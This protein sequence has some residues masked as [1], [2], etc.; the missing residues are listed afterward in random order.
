MVD[1]EELAEPAWITPEQIAEFV[2]Y[3]MF[4]PVQACL[5]AKMQPEIS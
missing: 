4:E 2:P 1:T 5:D 3:G